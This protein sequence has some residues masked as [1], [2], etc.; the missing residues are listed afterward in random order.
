MRARRALRRRQDGGG[1]LIWRQIRAGNHFRHCRRQ[2]RLGEEFTH[3]AMMR[4]AQS[5][6][7]ADQLGRAVGAMVVRCMTVARG[8][9]P[10]MPVIPQTTVFAVVPR[11]MSV[12]D[13]ALVRPGGVAAAVAMVVQRHRQRVGEQIIRHNQPDHTFSRQR[14]GDRF[15]R[16]SRV[17]GRTLLRERPGRRWTGTDFSDPVPAFLTGPARRYCIRI[18]T[19][20]RV[21]RQART[22]V[23]TEKT[24][25]ECLRKFKNQNPKTACNATASLGFFEFGFSEA[26]PTMAHGL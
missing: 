22:A 16:S 3:Q 2:R 15:E 6:R 20:V 13:R 23:E 17:R 1:T 9:M 14:H 12:S 8:A 4:G 18:V 11:D 19:T 10:V 5:A 26:G 21:G 7:R 25:L 24:K